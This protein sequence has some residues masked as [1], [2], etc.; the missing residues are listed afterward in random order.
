MT[1]GKAAR[2]AGLVFQGMRDLDIVWIGNR[3]SNALES[4]EH[5]VTGIRILSG[6]SARVSSRHHDLIIRIHEDQ[7]LD[8]RGSPVPMLLTLEIDT[9]GTPPQ[10]GP[11]GDTILAHAL[12]SLHRVLAADEIKWSAPGMSLSSADL[13]PNAQPANIILLQTKARSTIKRDI[14]GLIERRYTLPPISKTQDLL[15]QRLSRRDAARPRQGHPGGGTGSTMPAASVQTAPAPAQ[16]S[17]ALRLSAW[18]ISY[19]VAL[20]A[21]PVGGALLVINLLRGEDLRLSAHA[22]ALSG[23]YLALERLLG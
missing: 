14:P 16:T 18:L 19:C 9:A 23:T 6:D 8:G 20:F 2:S 4:L 10:D 21:L 15:L 12:R 5:S 17:A 7:R 1:A 11:Q 22:L 13:R 3:V